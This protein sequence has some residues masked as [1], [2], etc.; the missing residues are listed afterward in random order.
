MVED[1]PNNPNKRKSIFPRQKQ[2]MNAIAYGENQCI[3][4]D[5]W[6]PGKVIKWEWPGRRSP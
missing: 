1:L 4:R 3:M 2:N 6:I 5:E